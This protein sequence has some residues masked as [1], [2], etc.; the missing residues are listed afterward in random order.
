M[1]Y[2]VCLAQG[3]GFVKDET[4]AFHWYT[5]AAEQ[6]YVHAI[7][8]VGICCLSGCGTNKDVATGLKYLQL[9]SRQEHVGSLFRLGTVFYDG[10]DEPKISKKR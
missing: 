5:K 2:G 7:F 10:I 9:A 4:Q 3:V 1:A 8:I 6:K